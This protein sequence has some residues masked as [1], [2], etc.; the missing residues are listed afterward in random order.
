MKNKLFKI[1]LLTCLISC[2][3]SIPIES[4][5]E[6]EE[7]NEP[8]QEELEN[9][10]EQINCDQ[11]NEICNPK[12]LTCVQ[13]PQIGE[14]CD[15]DFDLCDKK[16]NGYCNQ[17]I[18]KCVLNV[19]EGGFCEFD[20]I[21]CNKYKN[22]I[23]SNNI[24]QR[25]EQEFDKCNENSREKCKE[26]FVCHAENSLCLPPLSLGDFC[27]IDFDLCNKSEGLFCD[28]NYGFCVRYLN[29]SEYCSPD[30]SLC[31]PGYYCDK[32]SLKC[33]R[34]SSYM[35]L[36]NQD[37]DACDSQQGLTCNLNTSKCD[38]Q[39]DN[40]LLKCD[41]D[42]NSCQLTKQD[43]YFCHREKSVCVRYYAEGNLCNS[44]NDLCNPRKDL[45]CDL[46]QNLCTRGLDFG[47]QCHLD[48]DKCIKRKHLKCH[49]EFKICFCDESSEFQEDDNSCLP[50]Q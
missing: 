11:Q 43:D 41:H 26:G 48:N 2:L 9:K 21:V 49:S 28:K 37:F 40:M 50:K 30:Y 25:N 12:T 13:Y 18:S 7:N 31:S 35:G 14:Q 45:F 6:E 19:P 3:L 1:F 23:C 34:L 17:D 42:S 24:C 22:L 4:R 46:E 16:S 32:K 20:G 5:E 39:I 8:E 27:A 47:M 36:C 29:E 44:E 10:C 38:G 33:V 15:H